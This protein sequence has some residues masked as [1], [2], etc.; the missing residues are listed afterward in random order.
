[1]SPRITRANSRHALVQKAEVPYLLRSRVPL[2]NASNVIGVNRGADVPKRQKAVRV[3]QN[4][5]A[6]CVSKQLCLFYYQQPVPHTDVCQDSKHLPKQADAPQA[7]SSLLL[8]IPDV[9]S[10]DAGDAQM[11]SEYV[12]DIYAYL[13]QLEVSM[14]IRPRYLE[15]QEV[16]GNMRAVAIDWLMQV[17][18]EFK[19]RQETLFMTVSIADCF[20][21]NNPVPKKYLQL[22]CVTAMLIAS[23]YEEI[24]PP[25]VG[26]FAFVTDGAYTCGD[27][28]RME[29][30]VL[31]RLNYSLGRPVPTH[32]LQRACKIG[33]AGPREHELASFLM[34]VAVLDYDLV[35]VPPSLMA[36]AAFAASLRILG[37]GQWNKNLEHYTG[38]SEETLAP[39]MQAII[40]M[41]EK[42]TDQCKLQEIKHKYVKVSS[43][44][45]K[46]DVDR[47]SS[48][49]LCKDRF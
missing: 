48:D 22:V 40:R 29:R 30:I 15:G 5:K 8:N 16:S 38:Y 10:A 21:Q 49:L 2:G 43:S 47:F 33:Q 23:K 6:N 9:D 32:F 24:Y 28:R 37:S 17:Q 36:A 7:F 39:V 14:A 35:H 13:Q 45:C 31:K 27:I 19:L 20:L 25:T 46:A 11:C 4:A 3:K 44:I 41:L 12:C 26:D 1:M 34:E 18:R 42:V